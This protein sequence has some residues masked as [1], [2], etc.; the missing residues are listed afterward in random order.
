M[1]AISEFMESTGPWCLPNRPRWKSVPTHAARMSTP[2]YLRGRPCQLNSQLQ[3]Y[4][5]LQM[6][7]L[8]APRFQLT[9]DP[10]HFLP[11]FS[12]PTA[13]IPPRI[14][15]LYWAWICRTATLTWSTS[16]EKTNMTDYMSRHPL[17]ETGKDHLEK[18]LRAVI[19]TDHVVVMDKIKQETAKNE[20]LRDWLKPF[21]KSPKDNEVST[22]DELYKKKVKNN[23]DKQHRSKQH[24]LRIGDA[25]VVKRERKR[26]AETPFEP[27]IYIITEIKSS[28]I[29]ATE[30]HSAEMHRNSSCWEQQNSPQH[31]PNQESRH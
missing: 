11:L 9:T 1:L 22:R 3:D 27:H 26:K 24:K 10:K 30:K 12:N 25:V 31:Q 14:E 18:H 6:Y 20:E 19:E 5:R 29:H 13:K 15:R 21:K 28:T 16:Q 7:L 23:H 8:G 17:P 4:S 2:H